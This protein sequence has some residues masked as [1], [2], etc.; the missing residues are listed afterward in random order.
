M[1][2]KY[3]W[4]ISINIICIEKSFMTHSNITRFVEQVYSS[5]SDSFIQI[6]CSS[7]NMHVFKSFVFIIF[8]ETIVSFVFGMENFIHFSI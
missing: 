6:Y 5:N 1:K 2:D 8:G 4:Y 3:I 7:W